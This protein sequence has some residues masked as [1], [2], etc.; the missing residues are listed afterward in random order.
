MPNICYYYNQC[1]EF[2]AKWPGVSINTPNGVR[3]K[4]AFY[5]G[6]VIDKDHN[7]FWTRKKGY[8]EFDPVSQ[9]CK[10]ANLQYIPNGSIQIDNRR[11]R[12]P[13]VVDF[14]DTYF[15]DNF[16]KGIGYDSVLDAID[17]S[18]RD[19]LMSM[20]YYYLLEDTANSYAEVWYQQNYVS[21][22]YPKANVA[23]QRISEFLH[24]LGSAE[25]KRNFLDSHIKYILEA[26]GKEV[27]IMIDST[28]MP[29]NCNLPITRYSTHGGDTNLEFRLITVVQK[30]TGLPLYYEVIHG[31]IVDISTLN[32]VAVIFK[33]MGCPIDYCLGDSGYCCPSVMERLILSGIDFMTRLNPTYN[34]Y[35]EVVS[36]NIDSLQ[37]KE[38]LV[39]YKDRFLYIKKVPSVIGTDK[40]TGQDCIG[41]IYLCL[42]IQSQSDQKRMLFNSKKINKM[43]AEEFLEATA[44]MGLF[45]IVD[46][47]DVEPAKLLPKYYL[48]QACEQYYD[49]G[50]NYAKFL[51]VRE[52]N[53][54]T[55][56]G[57]LLVSFIAV[58]L[59][60]MIKNRMKI[61]DSSYI[62]IPLVVE[63]STNDKSQEESFIVEDDGEGGKVLVKLIKQ[64]THVELSSVSPSIVFKELRA[65]KADVFVSSIVPTVPTR[66]A[67]DF[68]DSFH[69]A[70][71]LQVHRRGDVL[72]PE[73]TKDFTPLRKEHVFAR[74]Y[75]ITDEEVEVKKQ[76]YDAPQENTTPTGKKRGR[77]QGSKN[78]STL[79]K[80][81]QTAECGIKS[82]PKRKRGRPRK[83]IE[84]DSQDVSTDITVNPSNR[85]RGRPLGSKNKKTLEKEK[86]MVLSGIG[87]ENLSNQPKRKR[88]RP[89]GSKNKKK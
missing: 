27:C 36:N 40:N 28:G 18:N 41:Y 56:Q 88:G 33:N 58:S 9:Q 66:Q 35:R 63:D 11:H 3:K 69:I 84:T 73:F 7:I 34:M 80:E 37:D 74:K 54:E 77:P 29:N 50:K 48:R 16:I 17:Y 13:V 57:H 45:A 44:K 70:S 15:L 5:L 65:Q 89:R 68:Y 1:N 67:M 62:R 78:K 26:T 21:Y 47:K 30:S 38:N 6:K 81:K 24:R 22:L 43:S 46:T 79:E 19:R 64:N 39:Q 60:I 42:D 51:P 85:K 61:M 25:N 49:Y 14:G 32:R 20:I 71:P 86:L 82:Q 75:F 10:E 87:V 8:Y 59:L 4:G 72:K 23:S 12:P 52:H 76:K 2:V 31:N 83:T 55:L 53:L